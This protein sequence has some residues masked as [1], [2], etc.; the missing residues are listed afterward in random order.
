MAASLCVF[1][2][3]L[4]D[5]GTTNLAMQRDGSLGVFRAASLHNIAVTAP[6][7]HDGRFATLREVIDHYDHN[8]QNSSDLDPILRGI[9]GQPRRLNLSGEDKLALEAFLNALTDAE[10]LQDPKFSDPFQ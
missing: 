2:P 4:T 3:V 6:Y 8:V 10:L 9:D 7:M 1:A 5:L